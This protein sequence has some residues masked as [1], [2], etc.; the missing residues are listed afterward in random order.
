MGRSDGSQRI[1]PI[2]YEAA[3]KGWRV[4][5]EQAGVKN[6][7]LHDLRR[8]ASTRYANQFNGD[9]TELIPITGHKTVKMVMRYISVT[10][11]D[12][13]RLMHGH[14]AGDE[15]SPARYQ[16]ATVSPPLQA[17][18]P[19]QASSSPLGHTTPPAAAAVARQAPVERASNVVH[20]DF[21]RRVA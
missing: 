18:V 1:I 5:C 11:D 15:H 16:S 7:R 12:V 20:L 21:S 4:A 17:P 19:V 14:A 13:A 2:T 9:L 10:A 3:K 6:A 8:T